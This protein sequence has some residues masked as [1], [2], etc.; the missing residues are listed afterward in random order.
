MLTSEPSRTELARY[1][2]EPK[3]AELACY[4]AL[5]ATILR[6]GGSSGASGGGRSNALPMAVEMEPHTPCI[7]MPTTP[8][9]SPLLLL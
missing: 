2:N 3:Q 6:H 5:I 9:L 8:L 1:L 4:P 7:H